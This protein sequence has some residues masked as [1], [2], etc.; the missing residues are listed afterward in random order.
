MSKACLPSPWPLPK[1]E[2]SLFSREMRAL[3]NNDTLFVPGTAFWRVNRE[4]L[5]LN[6]A[7]S[8]ALLMELAHPLVAAGVAEYSHFRRHPLARLYR[9]G[10][11]MADMTFGTVQSALQAARHINNCHRRVR[12]VLQEGTGRFL[13]LFLKPKIRYSQR[14]AFKTLGSCNP[15]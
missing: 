15:D 11:S 3:S 6:L 10:R 7:G 4:L 2:T 1:E 5:L 14:S 12:G 13:P 8:R 9:T